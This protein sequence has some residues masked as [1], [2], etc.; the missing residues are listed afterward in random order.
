M[1]KPHQGSK[2]KQQCSND[3]TIPTVVTHSETGSGFKEMHHS[4]TAERGAGLRDV[5][6]RVLEVIKEIPATRHS[7]IGKHNRER[8]LN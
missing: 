5:E 1:P 2:E 8:V 3:G 4:V 6:W 7:G